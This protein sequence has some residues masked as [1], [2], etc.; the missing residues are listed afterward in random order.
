MYTSESGY[1]NEY[2]RPKVANKVLEIVDAAINENIYAIVDWHILRIM[3]SMNIK[4][5]P[6][7]F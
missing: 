2:I 6:R 1:I 4:S 3:I 7:F 5:T